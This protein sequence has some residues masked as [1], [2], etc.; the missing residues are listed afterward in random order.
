MKGRKKEKIVFGA[1]CLIVSMVLMGPIVSSLHAGKVINQEYVE[2]EITQKMELDADG[3]KPMATSNLEDNQTIVIE[4]NPIGS[5]LPERIEVEISQDEYESFI[6]EY[7]KL[8]SINNNKYIQDKVLDLFKKYNI[9]PEIASFESLKQTANEINQFVQEKY[10]LD[11]IPT[12]PPNKNGPSILIDETFV[13]LGCSFIFAT[14]MN[15]IAPIAWPPDTVWPFLNENYTFEFLG[16]EINISAIGTYGFAT[17]DLLVGQSINF[18]WIHSMIPLREF[19]FL[20]PFYGILI[21]P[22]GI[23]L[24]IYLKSNPPIILLDCIIGACVVGNLI[25]FNTCWEK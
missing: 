23:S 13:G 21:F 12:M 19:I 7:E 18:G 16:R 6:Y 20:Q 17:F 15:S 4:T 8:L 14:F 2:N 5:S 11:D 22:A 9:L 24:T 25:T 3:N 10:S 1:V